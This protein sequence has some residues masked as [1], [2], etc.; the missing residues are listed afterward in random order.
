L[1][2]VNVAAATGFA[3]ATRTVVVIANAVVAA[4]TLRRALMICPIRPKRP[5]PILMTIGAV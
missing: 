4:R 3:V 2:T 5:R 1:L